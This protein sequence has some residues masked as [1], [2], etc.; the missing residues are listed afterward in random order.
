[1][2]VLTLLDIAKMN[3]ADPAVPLIEESLPAAPEFGLLPAR[4]IAGTSFKVT[5]RT[6]N[7]VVAFRSA[8]NGADAVKSS[9]A[10]KLFETYYLEAPLQVDK[11]VADA[12]ERGAEHVQ[13]LE[14]QGVIQG[15]MVTV[16]KQFWYGTSNDSLGFPGA[17][18]V[19]D[20]SLV[21]DAT[22]TTA[23]T[24]S[25]VYLVVALPGFCEMLVGK[26]T[27]FALG[28]WRQQQILGANSKPM[29]AYVN[30]L[31]AYVGAAFYNKYALV[32]IKN[33][34]ED[35]GKGLTDS[36]LA[37][38][39][40]T[41]PVG[42]RPTHIFMSRRSNRQL[43]QSRTVVLNGNGSV[44]PNQATVAPIPTEYD[45]VPII[46]TDSIVDTETIA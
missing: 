14:A 43:Q 2:A 34:T 29:E 36:L 3:G 45:G 27:V 1:M 8:N 26:N 17:Q 39:F 25:S 38:A 19:V 35:S 22:G 40:A 31:S 7:P 9:Y 18:A 12:D 42:V 44:R 4:A 24:G 5:V 21:V 46:R 23:S 30:S 15:S 32:R 33:L 16:G 13:A 20:S 37:K 10:N 11:S 28:Q 41:L 6:A